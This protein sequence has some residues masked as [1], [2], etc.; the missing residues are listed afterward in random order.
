MSTV[1]VGGYQGR[2]TIA[3]EST[4]GLIPSGTFEHI[5]LVS[6]A[7]PSINVGLQPIRKLGI[8]D[9]AALVRGRREPEIRF[10]YLMQTSGS[11]VPVGSTFL[12]Q[13]NIFDDMTGSFT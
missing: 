5:G 1:I 4:Y 12:R 8:R 10:E 13:N 9:L 2:F 7:E 3:R 6:E 11:G